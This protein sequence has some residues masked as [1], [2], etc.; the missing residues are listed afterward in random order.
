MKGVT[1]TMGRLSGGPG[2]PR[3]GL[4]GPATVDF[5]FVQLAEM[6]AADLA[7]A[8]PRPLRRPRQLNRNNWLALVKKPSFFSP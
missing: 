6:E 4:Y 8:D 5:R 7:P 3:Q 1:G 2:W